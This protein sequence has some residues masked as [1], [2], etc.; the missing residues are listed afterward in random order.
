M[1]YKYNVIS[2][3]ARYSEFIYI[4]FFL[5]EKDAIEFYRKYKKASALSYKKHLLKGIF[6][7]KEQC[8]E[9]I[10]KFSTAVPTKE[11]A[12]TGYFETEEECNNWYEKY[13]K[14]HEKQGYK[15][16]KRKVK[17]QTI[18]DELLGNDTTTQ[19]AN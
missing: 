1:P 16:V 9:W 12:W 15:L 10:E 3:V 13:G 6:K 14:L 11:Q 18:I 7:D 5:M 4:E 2:D 19:E 17:Q 8:D